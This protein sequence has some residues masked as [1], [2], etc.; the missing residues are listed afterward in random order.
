VVSEDDTLMPTLPESLRTILPWKFRVSAVWAP[1]GMGGN[2]ETTPI[3]N[4][5]TAVNLS[6]Y[7]QRCK[8]IIT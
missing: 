5:A 8:N 6:L 3:T 4:T 1:I 2:S 7:S